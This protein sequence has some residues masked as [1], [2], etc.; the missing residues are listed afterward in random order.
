MSNKPSYAK[1]DDLKEGDRVSVTGF[2]CL[3]DGSEHEVHSSKG[4]R[5]GLYIKCSE[6]CHYLDGQYHETPTGAEYIGVTKIS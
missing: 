2:T 5:S 6:G 1:V 4:C 3:P